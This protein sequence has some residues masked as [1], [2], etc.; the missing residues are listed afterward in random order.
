[1]MKRNNSYKIDIIGNGINSYTITIYNKEDSEQFR[2][3]EMKSPQTLYNIQESMYS[4]TDA[5]CKEYFK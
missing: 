5:Q 4:L 3:F 1:M 2:R